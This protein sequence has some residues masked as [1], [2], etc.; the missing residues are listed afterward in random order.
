MPCSVWH[1]LCKIT[2]LELLSKQQYVVR[3]NIHVGVGLSNT[4][5]YGCNMNI[6]EVL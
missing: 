2:K 1:Y 6:S 4:T 5:N 3:E